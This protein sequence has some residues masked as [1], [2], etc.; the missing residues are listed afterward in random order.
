MIEEKEIIQE[1]VSNDK[2][3]L[4]VSTSNISNITKKINEEEDLDRVKDLTK[5]FHIAMMKKE[6]NRAEKQSDMLDYALEEV[7]NRM[8]T[9]DMSDKDLANYIKIFQDSINNTKK[10]TSEESMP[11]IQITNQEININNGET[12]SRESRERI[13]EVIQKILTQAKES[14]IIDIE[15]KEKENIEED[16]D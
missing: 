13:Q 5:L 11:K 12:L 4:P 14:D 1:E 9:G 6:I 16:D 7:N 15:P 3:D 2:K 8:L 10:N